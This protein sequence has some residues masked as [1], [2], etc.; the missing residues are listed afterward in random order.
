MSEGTRT[1]D[2][3]D[4]NQELYQLSYA[5][6][7]STESSNGGACRWPTH[8]LEPATGARAGHGLSR[9]TCGSWSETWSAYSELMC[10]TWYCRLASP[11]VTRM[12]SSTSEMPSKS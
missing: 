5:H 2:R 1:P 8:W 3:L 9:T 6:R 4:H 11:R 10:T 7:E 12:W